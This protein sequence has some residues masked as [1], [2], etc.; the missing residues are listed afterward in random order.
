VAQTDNNDL[1]FF[2]DR[3]KDRVDLSAIIA[4]HTRLQKYGANF[5]A[6]CPL[7]GHKEKTPSFHINTRDNYFYCYGCNRGGDVFNFLQM[8][9]GLDFMEALQS[10]AD[11]LGLE[12]PKRK[13]SFSP[14]KNNLNKEGFEFLKRAQAYYSRCLDS[15]LGQAAMAYLNERGINKEHIEKYYL[16]WAPLSFDHNLGKKLSSAQEKDLAIKTGL[17]RMDGKNLRD[18]FVNRLVIPICDHRGRVSGFSGRLIKE[19]ANKKLPKYKNSSESDWFQKKRILYG[20][21]QSASLIREKDYVCVVEGYFD[22]WALLAKNIPAVAVMGTSLTEDHLNLLSRYSKNIILILDSDEAGTRS[23]LRSMEMLL[24]RQFLVKVFSCPSSKD[25]DEW[26]NS[27]KGILESHIERMIHMSTEGIVWW[28]QHILSQPNLKNSNDLQKITALKELWNSLSDNSQ[29]VFFAKELAPSFS[30][31]VDH[32]LKSFA[33]SGPTQSIVPR[34]KMNLASVHKASMNLPKSRLQ[35]S[36]GSRLKRQYR[37]FEHLVKNPR[38]FAL[39]RMEELDC[40]KNSP[41]DE[42]MQELLKVS[43]DWTQVEKMAE[44]LQKLLSEESSLNKESRTWLMEAMVDRFNQVESDSDKALKSFNELRNLCLQD[45]LSSELRGL[46]QKV[47]SFF[48]KEQELARLLQEMQEIRIRL[49][50]LK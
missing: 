25:P 44:L 10:L 21:Y 36:L 7:P 49:E 17:C 34:A 39:L 14:A 15:G 5:K 12:M 29:K 28:S 35:A 22:Q 46:Q 33:Y 1:R 40:L 8:V 11:S 6:N 24:K 43:D 23:T 50:K 47:K 18:F 26:L 27:E 41:A 42:V 19:E 38:L 31:N 3:V 20:L 2:K 13:T 45:E 30:M 9:E 32:F 48:G 16:G 37:L 4:R